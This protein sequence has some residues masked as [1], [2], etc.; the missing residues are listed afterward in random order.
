MASCTAIETT[1]SMTVGMG[2]IVAAEAPVCLTAVLGSCIGAALYHPGSRR[3]ALAHMVL[4]T[5][6]G[7][8]AGVGKF[9]DTA[10]PHMLQWFKQYGI[11]PAR[12]AVKVT[13]GACMFGGGGPVQIGQANIEAVMQILDD[14]GVHVAKKD[15]GGSNGRRISFDC[16]TGL[17]TIHTVGSP[18]RVL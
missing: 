14:A 1:G 3:G 11:G 6:T 7:R 4:P 10:I 8:I 9:A 15:V 13:G 17:L 18:P 16:A 2:Q 5:S 12:L